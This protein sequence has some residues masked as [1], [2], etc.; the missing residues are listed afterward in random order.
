MDL[1]RFCFF[2]RGCHDKEKLLVKL[3]EARKIKAFENSEDKENHFIVGIMELPRQ[4]APGQ[5]IIEVG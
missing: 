1:A 3:L 4:L 5:S 2:Q